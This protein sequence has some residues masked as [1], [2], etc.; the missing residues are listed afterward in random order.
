MKWVLT[1]V[2]SKFIHSSL[3]VWY[4]HAVLPQSTVREFTINQ[5]P[6]TVLEQLIEEKPDVLGFSCYIWNISFIKTLLPAIKNALPHCIIVLGGPEVSHNPEDYSDL[7]HYIVCGYGE[8]PVQTL[9]AAL[10]SGQ[11]LPQILHGDWGQVPPSPYGAD[12]FSALNGRIAYLEASRGCPFTCGFCL[13]GIAELPVHFPLEQVKADIIALANSGTKTI[14]FVDRTF[15]AHKARATEIWQ[16][17][18]TCP[19]IPSGVCFHFEIGADL[20]TAEHLDILKTAPPGKFQLEIGLQSF[21]EPTLQAVQRK[22]SV[23]KSVDNIGVLVDNSNIHVHIDLIVGLPYETFGEFRNSFN[24]AYALKAH[25]LQMGFLKL[26]HGSTLRQKANEYDMVYSSQPPYE[27][28]SLNCMTAEEIKILKGLE[29]SL[30][31]LYNSGRFPRTLAFLLATE[32]TTAFDLFLNISQGISYNHGISLDDFTNLVYNYFQRHGQALRSALVEDRLC[33]DNTGLLPKCL[34]V[35][36]P[37]LSKAKKA[38]AKQF[39]PQKG[40]RR[41]VA[42]LYDRG[43]A[44]WCDYIQPH[45]VTGQYPLHY[46]EI[47]EL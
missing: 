8:Q 39:P 43:Q 40:I 11:A 44:V 16:F 9:A 45:P 19:D 14:K 21:Y 24:Q 7:A 30:E 2:N 10:E 47:G 3:S 4:L 20:L 35:E 34:H 33:W 17:I 32:Q 31:K 29:D 13:S 23:D 6:Q 46:L 41:G 1:A 27:I 18:L 25:M 5:E 38:I 15:N 22:T 36:D 37:L 26:L 12:Y 28:Q 42:L